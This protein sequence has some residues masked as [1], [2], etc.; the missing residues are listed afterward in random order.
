VEL[1]PGE[2]MAEHLATLLNAEV[3]RLQK[4]K[5]VRVLRNLGEAQRS[6]F[7]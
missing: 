6:G 4:A 1:A 3:P 5:D 7:R 2:R